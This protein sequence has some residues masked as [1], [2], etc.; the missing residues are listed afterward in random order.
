MDLTKEQKKIVQARN[1]NILVSAAA[2][3]GKTAVLVER[4]MELIKEGYDVDEL[5][6]VTFTRAAASS[7]R[8]KIASRIEEEAALDMFNGHIVKQLT[9]I[10]KAEITTIDSFCLGIVKDHFNQAGVDSNLK[11]G[12]EAEMELL[13]SDVFSDM[14]EEEYKEADSAFTDLVECFARKESDEKLVDIIS[15]ISKTANSFPEPYLWYDAAV[16]ALSLEDEEEMMKLPWMQETIKD[17]CEKI[18]CC[19]DMSAYCIN[20]IETNDGFE[21]YEKSLSADYEYFMSLKSS[22]NIV[23]TLAR[24]QYKFPVIGRLSGDGFD[25]DIQDSIK[26]VREVYK[27][28]YKGCTETVR[29]MKH[30]RDEYIIMGRLLIKLIKLADRFDNMLLAEKK[31]RNSYEFH[32]IEHMAFKLVCDGSNEDGSFIPS[33]I[34]KTISEEYKE[35]MIDEYQD[36]NYLQEAVLNCVSGAGADTHNIFMVGDVKQ[37][38]Y[39]FRMARPELFLEKYNTYSEENRDYK[40]FVLSSNFRSRK[41]VLDGVNT[42]F[43]RL[44]KKDMGNIDYSRDAYLDYCGIDGLFPGDD[45]PIELLVTDEKS[46]DDNGDG[47]DYIFEVNK[48]ELEACMVLKRI[49][50]ITHDGGEYRYGDIVILMRSIKQTGPVFQQ[51]ADKMNIPLQIES[52]GGFFDATEVSVLLSM[53]S[54]VDN[55]Y[56]DYE[57][58]AALKSPLAG[59]T[60]GELAIIAGTYKKDKPDKAEKAMFYDKVEYYVN[61]DN[62][63]ETENKLKVFLK[64]LCYLKQNKQY[65][66]ISDMLRYILNETGYYWYVGALP[67][68]KKRQ[69]NI[70]ALISRADDFEDSSFKGVFNFLRYINRMKINSL[71]FGEPSVLDENENAV[72]LMTMHKSKGLEFPVVFVSGL[73]KKFNE[74]DIRR[75]V[76]VHSDYYLISDAYDAGMRL[77]RATFAKKAAA[78][79][80]KREMLGEEL[81]VLYVALTRAKDRLIM[82]AKVSDFEKL[83]N[84]A[85]SCILDNDGYINYVERS[86]ANTYMDWIMRTLSAGSGIK[87]M[88][89]MKEYVNRTAKITL[90]YEDALKLCE[91]FRNDL[92]QR[93]PH[94][95]RREVSDILCGHTQTET[96]LTAHEVSMTETKLT[97]PGVSTTESDIC[98]RISWVMSNRAGHG[99]RSKMSVTDIKK[100]RN[101]GEENPG[102]EPFAKVHAENKFKENDRPVLKVL[103]PSESISGSRMGTV[104]HKLMENIDFSLT[105]YDEI[106]ADI[107][108]MMRTGILDEAYRSKV[109]VRK[110]CD[111]VSGPLG[112]RMYE[113]DRKNR[114]YRERQ[115]YIAM[116]VSEIY[117]NVPDT[118]NDTIVVQGIIDAYFVEEDGIVLVDYKTDYAAS[119]YELV[120]K[121]HVQLEKYAETLNRLTGLPVKEKLI[122]S[123]H[124]DKS[125]D[126][127]ID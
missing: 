110:I 122:Y 111:M 74:M 126:C 19:A 28:A 88:E 21:K 53:L 37:S 14:L 1:C 20:L 121:Y 23:D 8:E 30:V 18:E 108:N 119:P 72:R 81:R 73:G 49:E 17:L 101:N 54:C 3:S 113:A 26:T 109:S 90:K 42:I 100:M 67:M 127:T 57:L 13:K 112:R 24:E 9:L 25:T 80:I 123:F 66:S 87:G 15:D 79:C 7:M 43:S 22:E 75:N 98:E 40:K 52:E 92:P 83:I 34:G 69:A 115:F 107:D 6:V 4:I 76:L 51:L 103:E 95:L 63:S 56:Q 86:S 89:E 31:K 45:A 36:S 46:F 29:L 33:D 41:T 70:D 84:S 118:A 64:M 27:K 58:V 44:M 50:E 85:S 99:Y 94:D 11:V 47:D 38:I 2:G 60:S 39:K 61:L 97:A 16:N 71:D 32:D 10:N 120:R 78:G 102:Y 93:E 91:W 62:G 106:S 82:S 59:I 125:I 48:D 68:G 116:D 77:K 117:D 104:I 96:E 105:G 5:L 55:S 35:I 124:F 114:L 12:D 65:M